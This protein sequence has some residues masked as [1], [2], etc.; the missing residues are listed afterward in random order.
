MPRLRRYAIVLVLCACTLERASTEPEPTAPS[1]DVETGGGDAGRPLPPKQ[2]VPPR[3]PQT[4]HADAALPNPEP[5][6]CEALAPSEAESAYATD[7]EN[8]RRSVAKVQERLLQSRQLWVLS[9][10]SQ[11]CRELV[12]D[13]SEWVWRGPWSN[14]GAA[15][16]RTRVV[17]AFSIADRLEE[18]GQG[19]EV[20][21]AD[22]TMSG[23]AGAILDTE[24][25]GRF[26]RFD[27]T[28][29]DFEPSPAPYL[30]VRCE[31]SS[32]EL[33]DGTVCHCESNLVPVLRKR[34]EAGHAYGHGHTRKRIPIARTTT[35]DGTVVETGRTCPPCDTVDTPCE[36][37]AR[38]MRKRLGPWRPQL[39][40]GTERIPMVFWTRAACRK[41]RTQQ[42]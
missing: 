7:L 36:A 16:D 15:G 28:A 20:S 14:S 40:Q 42:P 12:R 19:M 39:P 18:R 10:D 17:R 2:R 34:S 11:Q 9:P 32:P 35:A 27:E 4:E 31:D 38:C 37:Q 30:A 25:H 24:V 13:D 22:G 26:V 33:Q 29:I 3:G 5:P 41:Q 6:S 23:S 21:H 8:Y 1:S